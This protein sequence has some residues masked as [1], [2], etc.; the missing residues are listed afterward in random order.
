MGLMRMAGDV[1]DTL[2]GWGQDTVDTIDQ[3]GGFEGAGNEI[4]KPDDY[5]LKGSKPNYPMGSKG[6]NRMIK[7]G[8]L[9]AVAGPVIN[10]LAEKY[11]KP[12][13]EFAGGWTADRVA[14]GIVGVETAMTAP[15]APQLP[16]PQVPE[17]S[18]KRPSWIPRPTMAAMGI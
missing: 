2:E 7:G 4:G 12:V 18:I 8:V 5:G 15:P 13:A 17:A 16:A 3:H 11:V 10:D 1:W 9:G 6:S 14:E